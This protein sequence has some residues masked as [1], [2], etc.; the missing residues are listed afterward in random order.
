MKRLPTFIIVL[1]F[2]ANFC[3]GFITTAI[4]TNLYLDNN[5]NRSVENDPNPYFWLMIF[6]PDGVQTIHFKELEEFRKNHSVYSFLVPKGKE[7]YYNEKLASEYRKPSFHFEVEQISE[8]KQLIKLTS[9]GGKSSGTDL[10]EATDKEI[11]PKTSSEFNLKDAF[12]VLVIA[13]IG[14]TV[15]CLISFVVYKKFIIKKFIAV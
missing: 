12:L 2:I 4:L 6:T 1:I 10:Y 7:T 8:N 14:G 11:F 13:S 3:V 5:N 15:T 9:D